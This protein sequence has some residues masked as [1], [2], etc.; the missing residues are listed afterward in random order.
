[1]DPL[2][3][4]KDIHLPQAVGWWPP[5]IGWWLLLSLA[6]VFVLLLLVFLRRQRQRLAPYRAAIKECDRIAAEYDRLQDTTK[7]SQQLSILLR[8][9]A[10]SIMPREDVAGLTGERWLEFLDN[11]SGKTILC[12]STGRKLLQAPYRADMTVDGDALLV[13]CRRWISAVIRYQR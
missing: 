9:V 1:M 5:A 3:A 8:R 13:V 11:L 12:T 6:L 4:L 2:A 7:L 10:I